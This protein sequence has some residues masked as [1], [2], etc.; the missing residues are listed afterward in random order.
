MLNNLIGLTVNGLAM[1][2]VY[3]LIAMG[4][5]LLVRAVGVMNFAQGDL[6]MLGAYL[7]FTFIVN[8]KLPYW[9]FVPASLISFAIV[10]L[11]F[12]AVTYWPLREAS[13]PQAVIIATMGAGYVIKEL[14]YKIWGPVALSMP[15]LVINPETGTTK[16]LEIFGIKLQWQYVMIIAV[17]AVLIVLV[18]ML[19]E[20]LYA[21]RMMQATAQDKYAAEL[22][23]IPSVVTIA[24]T[25]ML[26]TMVVSIGGYMVAPV[27]FI[28]ATLSSL[29]L[30]AFA[31]VVIGGFG[32]L[33]GAIIGSLIVGLIE[34]YATLQW[35]SYKDAVV[36]IVLIIVLIFRPQGLF[37]EKIA[38]KA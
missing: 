28:S 3:A 35:S 19:F 9:L 38:D 14:A 11:I 34:A 18:F 6:F 17:C 4:L 2:V 25:Y 8:I 37:G 16:V 22:I 33:K 10:G 30:R 27:F 26:V 12:M 7:S 29:Q 24:A 32:N 23:G 13:Y 36:F 31:G 21:G 1:G 5:I 20:K 15:A